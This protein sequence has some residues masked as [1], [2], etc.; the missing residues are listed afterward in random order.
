MLNVEYIQTSSPGNLVISVKVILPI[1]DWFYASNVEFE[2][3]CRVHGVKRLRVVDASVL[4]P[5]ASV[6]GAL[7]SVLM[8]A[9]RAANIISDAYR[10]TS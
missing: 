1:V 8:L 5:I 4:P 6:R 9:E 10:N 2:M 3:Y 7:S